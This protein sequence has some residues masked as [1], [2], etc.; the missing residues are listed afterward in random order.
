MKNSVHYFL[1]NKN[2]I[3]VNTLLVYKYVLK[4]TRLTPKMTKS[5]CHV[6][7]KWPEYFPLCEDKTLSLIIIH[8]EMIDVVV[9]RKLEL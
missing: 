4:R 8:Y 3:I 9:N 5:N 2:R 7:F 1:E 6:I